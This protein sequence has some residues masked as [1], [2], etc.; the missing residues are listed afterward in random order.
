MAKL[1]AKSQSTGEAKYPSDMPL[2]A[3]GLC[4]AM[5]FT[6]QAAGK[7]VAIDASRAL[8]L[9]GVVRFIS[10]QDIPGVNKVGGES[11]K[12]FLEIG[13]EAKCIG[14][15]VGL[16]IATSAQIAN[17]AQRFV[18]VTYEI[19][20]NTPDLI[21]N[22]SDAIDKDSFFDLGDIPGVTLIE[23]GDVDTAM[24]NAPH[25]S[26]GST[27][28]AG[29]SHFY[30]V[31]LILS[32]KCEVDLNLCHNNCRSVKLLFLNGMMV[33]FSRSHVELRVQVVFNQW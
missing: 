12:L 19:S 28:T 15:P 25:R 16:I 30:M 22:L 27:R 4:G 10:A 20:S 8:S 14:H 26:K 1:E 9:P 33:S 24:V 6:T 21:T 17:D 5:V 18:Q 13:D 32:L 23:A 29:Q 7:I 11:I 3:Q 2:P 31:S